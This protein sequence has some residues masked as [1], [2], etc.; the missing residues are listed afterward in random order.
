MYK[1]RRANSGLVHIPRTKLVRIRDMDCSDV[2]QCT[3]HDVKGLD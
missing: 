1:F 3:F 2:A